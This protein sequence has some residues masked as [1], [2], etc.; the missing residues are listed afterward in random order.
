MFVIANNVMMNMFISTLFLRICC[1]NETTH[2]ILW[3]F[4][5][6]LMHIAGLLSQGLITIYSKISNAWDFFY[7]SVCLKAFHTDLQKEKKNLCKFDT[8]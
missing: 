6:L 5:K 1:R 2:Q 3:I 4:I 7:R 8:T